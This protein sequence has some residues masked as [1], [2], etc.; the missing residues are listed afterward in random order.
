MNETYKNNK[1]YNILFSKREKNINT[2]KRFCLPKIAEEYFPSQQNIKIL[3]KLPCNKSLSRTKKL[4]KNIFLTSSKYIDSDPS[5]EQEKNNFFTLDN[6][7]NPENRIIHKILSDK[8]IIKNKNLGKEKI[9]QRNIILKNYMNEAILYRKSIFQKNK[10][11]VGR[12]L[13]IPHSFSKNFKIG[14]NI[15]LN[16]IAIDFNLNSYLNESKKK[17]K[18]YKTLDKTFEIDNL[19]NYIKPNLKKIHCNLKYNFCKN[20]K[21]INEINSILNN[22]NEDSKISFNGYRSQVFKIIDN[23]YQ[24]RNSNNIL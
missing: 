20:Q 19:K 7:N 5:K 2:C 11:H 6:K 12:I 23:T 21:K 18:K 4:K 17:M 9:F 22:L 10:V 1:N 16:K 24:H 14:K 13:K 3:N 8:I 15:N